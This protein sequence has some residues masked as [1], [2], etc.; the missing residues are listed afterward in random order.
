MIKKIDKDIHEFGQ[1]ERDFEELADMS[2]HGGW[3][4]R[5]CLFFARLAR[6]SREELIEERDKDR[7]DNMN[8]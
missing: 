3:F 2:K 6:E 8:G 5:F 4:A 7:R 1:I